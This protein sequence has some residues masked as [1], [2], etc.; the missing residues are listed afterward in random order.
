MTQLTV[1][2]KLARILMC[3]P[4]RA[5]EFGNEVNWLLV[6]RGHSA[7]PIDQVFLAASSLD[8]FTVTAEDVVSYLAGPSQPTVY[9]T[10]A[11]YTLVSTPGDENTEY[12]QEEGTENSY[13]LQVVDI[14]DDELDVV[15]IKA[16]RDAALPAE[17]QPPIPL[18]EN[19]GQ[20]LV[21]ARIMVAKTKEITYDQIERAMVEVGLDPFTHEET[22]TWVIEHLEAQGVPVVDSSAIGADHDL[23]TISQVDRIEIDKVLAQ[24]FGNHKD[25]G[26][27]LLT[28]EEQHRLLE[29]VRAGR[30][31]TQQLSEKNLDDDIESDLLSI[32]A[33]G[34]KALNELLLRNRRLV[35]SVALKFGKHARHLTIE[36]LIQEGMIG[37]MHAIDRFDLDAGIRLSTYGTWW[38]RQAI[39]RAI[40]DQDRTI[41]LPVH[42]VE[43]V[44]RYLRAV[45]CL[46]R[47]LSRP[48][49]EVE[50]AVS[51]NILSPRVSNQVDA[52]REN[53][54]EVPQILMRQLTYAVQHVQALQQYSTLHP[55]SLD[56]PV[57]DSEGTS[58]GDLVPDSHFQSPETSAFQTVLCD[59]INA[60]LGGLNDRERNVIIYRYGLFGCEELTLEVLGKEM[61]VTR[62]RIRQI[63]E[64]ALRKLRH[65]LRSR[66]LRDFV[67]YIPIQPPPKEG[68]TTSQGEIDEHSTDPMP[69]PQS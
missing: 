48:P 66:K 52:A 50:I 3:T 12:A 60:L 21:L 46:E 16:P 32:V 57:G 62:E 30:R 36:D 39:S 22:Y 43:A 25:G 7:I 11:P 68:E 33:A 24:V 63:Q 17:D 10:A 59:E 4:S 19:D 6:Q 40:A 51:L 23:A 61:D 18:T 35:A 49:T 20:R 34:K 38:V 53:G 45:H 67:D 42:R 64:K 28:A 69:E 29:V 55:V 44:G 58:L 54:D 26:A 15:P 56:T 31:A 1:I 13:D 14:L 8:V 27:E 47:D 65:P 41:R 2:D 5:R 37:L 9:A